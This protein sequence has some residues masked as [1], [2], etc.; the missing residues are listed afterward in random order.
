M[1]HVES[2]EEIV[3]EELITFYWLCKRIGMHIID[4]LFAEQHFEHIYTICVFH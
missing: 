2:R 4:E 1:L 3:W